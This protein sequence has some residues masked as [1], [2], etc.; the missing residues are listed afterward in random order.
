MVVEA[1][2]VLRVAVPEVVTMELKVGVALVSSVKLLL[3]IV[4]APEMVMT[5][6]PVA[7]VSGEV[8]VAA[9]AVSVPVTEVSP[10]VM[11]EKPGCR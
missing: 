5:P 2:A 8:Q 7:R 9:P 3:P 11:P 4:C 1:L 10:M 6:E